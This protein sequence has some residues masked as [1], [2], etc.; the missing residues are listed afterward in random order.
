MKHLSAF[1]RNFGIVLVVLFGL[2]IVAVSIFKDADWAW[3]NS[4]AANVPISPPQPDGV[5]DLNDANA[6]QNF[7]L[8]T[9]MP[10]KK[11]EVVTGVQYLSSDTNRID[12]QWC[13]LSSKP[14]VGSAALRIQL[15]D[16]NTKGVKITT[17]LSRKTL[18]QF[19]ITQ[20]AAKALVLSHC[21]FQ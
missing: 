11:F 9:N 2:T 5:A 1:L 4:K 6:I 19:N 18:Q 8:F 15:A 16:I 10:Y 21:R 13:Y 3:L 20:A 12:I 17:S 14:K 7:V